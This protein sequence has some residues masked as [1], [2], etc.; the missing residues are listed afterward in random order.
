MPD[1][2]GK[3]RDPTSLAGK[4]VGMTGGPP[5]RLTLTQFLGS[6]LAFDG[7]HLC[8]EVEWPIAQAQWPALLRSSVDVAAQL[9][10][11]VPDLEI[12]G[13]AGTLV[14]ARGLRD[15]PLSCWLDAFRRLHAVP[16]WRHRAVTGAEGALKLYLACPYPEPLGRWAALS[17]ELLGIAARAMAAASL[18]VNA[19]SLQRSVRGIGAGLPPPHT[20]AFHAALDAAHIPWHWRQEG[21]TM[22]GYGSRQKAV[23]PLRRN[24]QREAR[25]LGRHDLLIP[26]Y[27][28]TG[29]VGKTTTARL[30]AQLFEDSG[31]RVGLTASDGGWAAGRQVMKGDCI[32]ATAASSMLQ[33]PDIDLAV[34]EQGR[35]GIL[36]QGLPY[37]RSDLAVL[38]NILP[39]H[40]GKDGV[41]TLE[42]L[43]DV[44]ARTVERARIAVLNANDGQ[45]RRIGE[46]RPPESCVWFSGDAPPARLAELST[47]SGGALGIRRSA[48]GKPEAISIWLNGEEEAALPLEGVAPF[49]GRLGEKTVEELLAVVAAARFGPIRHPD[50]GAGLRKLRLDSSNHAF[51]C[52]LHG[53]GDILFVLDKAH[54]VAELEVLGPSLKEI[55]AERSIAH[56]ICV[57]LLSVGTPMDSHRKTCRTLHGMADEFICYDNPESYAM[58]GA[59]PEY[60]PGS[61]LPLVNEEFERLNAERETAKPIA[62]AADWEAAERSIVARLAVAPRPVM[63]VVLQPITRAPETSQ[64][65]L[66]FVER[67]SALPDRDRSHPGFAPG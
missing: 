62:V 16:V 30:M 59:L 64:R 58:T 28:V 32:G 1:S 7:A 38:L 27:T 14:G 10:A 25:E 36:M 4:I 34:L 39:L 65:M 18:D 6:T 60:A 57:F 23:A 52:S 46:R 20:M 22:V 41:N 12:V 44:K 9:S 53:E 67:V 21:D 48:S 17:F 33:R 26:I 45:C 15:D 40:L 8:L 50:L 24:P 61:M 19:A 55:S 11:L 63:V 43:A 56:R 54:S 31:R 51:R 13:R 3:R 49:H 47:G 66:R 5:H 2:G 42:E 37:A 35:G 29:S